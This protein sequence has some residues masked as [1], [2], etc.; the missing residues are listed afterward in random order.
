MNMDYLKIIKKMKI[1][2]GRWMTVKSL[3]KAS[4]GKTM[5]NEK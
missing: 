2:Y 3:P 1:D 5:K 4:L